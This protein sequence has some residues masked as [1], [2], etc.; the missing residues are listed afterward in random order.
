MKYKN[1]VIPMVWPRQEGR[2]RCKL[3]CR[4]SRKLKLL[5][6]EVDIWRE[7]AAGRGNGTAT[8]VGKG[9]FRGEEVRAGQLSGMC[10]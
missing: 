7:A 9:L 5:G 8:A 2:G 10:T 3:A 1:K 4:G 6:R